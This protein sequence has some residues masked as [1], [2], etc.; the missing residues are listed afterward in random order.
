MDKNTLLYRSADSTSIRI[1]C[2]KFFLRASNIR[3]KDSNPSSLFQFSSLSEIE[4]RILFIWD[5]NPSPE[6]WIFST[7][8]E[9]FALE[10]RFIF[11]SETLGNLI[12]NNNTSV[13]VL[14]KSN[15]GSIQQIVKYRFQNP[16]SK[17]F[18]NQAKQNVFLESKHWKFDIHYD[19][20]Q[21]K[22]T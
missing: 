14:S 16:F 17:S 13:L 2:L 5:S 18:K 8:S 19:L 6:C 4:I 10:V 11:I 12:R 22:M 21:L 7:L 15:K 3:Q 9:V 1:F 20:L